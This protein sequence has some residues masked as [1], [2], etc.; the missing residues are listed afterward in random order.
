MYHDSELHV[1][2]DVV[3]DAADLAVETEIIVLDTDLVC[4]VSVMIALFHAL[5]HHEKS[6]NE[7]E[8]K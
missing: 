8:N 3:E 1:T 5:F 7:H 4:E 6:P 2:N